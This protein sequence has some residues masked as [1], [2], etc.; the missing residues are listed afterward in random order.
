ME[1]ISLVQI[2][3]NPLFFVLALFFLDQGRMDLNFPL[4]LFLDHTNS[5]LIEKNKIKEIFDPKLGARITHSQSIDLKL[6]RITDIK[7]QIILNL[8]N[9]ITDIES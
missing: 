1:S 3:N 7:S 9:Q 4:F 6:S 2:I 5:P 8:R